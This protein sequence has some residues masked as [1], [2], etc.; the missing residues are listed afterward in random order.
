M[1]LTCPRA[2]AIPT[3][4]RS[5]SG[6]HSD[7]R[8]NLGASLHPLVETILH[9]METFRFSSCQ[10]QDI[11]FRWK[12]NGYG[13]LGFERHPLLW[14]FMRPKKHQCSIL[15]EPFDGACETSNSLQ[16]KKISSFSLFPSGQCSTS[17]GRPDYGNPTKAGICCLTQHTVRI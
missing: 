16:K 11:F 12:Y 5:V 2:R 7:L 1:K 15:F 6:F 3:R 8:R 4:R 9:A 13:A 17:Y 10:G 14:F